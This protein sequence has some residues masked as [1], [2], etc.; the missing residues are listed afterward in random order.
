MFALIMISTG[1]LEYGWIFNGIGHA[2]PL[3]EIL[4]CPLAYYLG[5][6]FPKPV[7]LPKT[8]LNIMAVISLIITILSPLLKMPVM[9]NFIRILLLSIVIHSMKDGFQQNAN[10]FF[11]RLLYAIGGIMSIL[12]VDIPDILFLLIGI[13]ALIGLQG[14]DIK[15]LMSDQEEYEDYFDVKIYRTNRYHQSFGITHGK[16]RGGYS[17]VML[18]H[19]LC[20]YC[21]IHISLIAILSTFDSFHTFSGNEIL[22]FVFGI[23]AIFFSPLF[24]RV[25]NTVTPIFYIGNII[26]FSILIIMSF[27]EVNSVFVTLYLLS[28]MGKGMDCTIT[29]K[30]MRTNKFD[31]TSMNISQNIGYILGIVM[32]VIISMTF[33]DTAQTI[34][35]IL[36]AISIVLSMLCMLLTELKQRIL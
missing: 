19:T 24:F 6:M 9:T 16:S 13:T 4:C 8:V 21:Y 20:Y 30:S 31:E 23:L 34:M 35:L 29:K 27:L 36:G 33:A 5:K 1:I 32:A 25:D 7:T 26:V 17:A 22:L 15:I 28:V 18:F 3:Y 2:L 14:Y 12:A 11:K 10:S